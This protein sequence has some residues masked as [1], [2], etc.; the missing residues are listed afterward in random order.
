[1]STKEVVDTNVTELKRLSR[2]KDIPVFLISSLNRTNYMTPVD[3]EAFKESGAIEFT[4]DCVWGLQLTVLN[5]PI[6]DKE[7]QVKKKR[8]TIREAKAANPREV[9][10]VCLKNRYGISSYKVSFTYY[11]QF[12]LFK[13]A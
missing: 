12:D 7:G 8:E 6:F 13:E 2:S 4:A 3:F 1:M 10:L 5:D 11:P 9:E